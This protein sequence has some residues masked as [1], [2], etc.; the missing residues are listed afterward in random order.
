MARS[1]S[2][3][4]TGDVS[5]LLAAFAAAGSAGK[6]FGRTMDAR[7][8]GAGRSMT[9][10]LTLPVVA[11]F[12]YAAKAAG[13]FETELNTFQA[14]SGATARQLEQ[15]SSASKK[16]GADAKL[17]GASA[18][19]A[20]VAMTELAKGGLSVK[21]SMAAARGTLLLAAAAETDNAT[22][23]T[24]VAD[25]LNAFGLAGKDAARV[26]DLLAASANASTASIDDMAQGLKQSS[27]VAKQAGVPVD[28]ATAALARLA[29]AGIKGSD[30]G[31]SFKT[32]L[33]RLMAPAGAGA[34][35]IKELGLELRDQQGRL[36]PLPALADEF[37]SKLKEMTPAQRDA[38]LAAIF[39]SDAIRAANVLLTKGGAAQDQMRKKVSE[40][41]AAQK[42][43]EA[44]MKGFN[45]ALEAFSSTAETL[46]ITLGA[47]LL[48][49][50]TWVLR[51]FTNLAAGIDGLPGPLRGV[52][53]G[54]LTVVAAAG[55]MLMVIGKMVSLFGEIKSAVESVKSAMVTLNTTWLALNP[56]LMFLA[57]AGGLAVAMAML[58]SKSTTAASAMGELKKAADSA[59]DAVL[60]FRDAL[61]G[62]NDAQTTFR[63]ATLDHADALERY[64]DVQR[65]VRS[66]EITGAA[67]K[68]ELAA[69]ELAVQRS[70]NGVARARVGIVRANK[71]AA[72]SVKELTARHNEERDAALRA[73]QRARTA[74]QVTPSASTINAR[75]TAEKALTDTLNRQ[76]AELKPLIAE[77]AKAGR[78]NTTAGKQARE[79]NAALRAQRDDIARA[80]EQMGPTSKAANA[81]GTAGRNGA[82]GIRALNSAAKSTP[83][84]MATAAAGAHSAGAAIS[85]GLINGI[86]S[87]IGEIRAASARVAREAEAAQR[88]AAMINSPSKVFRRL[89]QWMGAG[90]AKGLEDSIP[91][92]RS[93][94]ASVAREAGTSTA[95]GLKS[96]GGKV[97]AAAKELAERAKKALTARITAQK[98][99]IRT[100]YERVA[101]AAMKA[102][103]D[104]TDE[105]AA[106]RQRG[107]DGRA[108]GIDQAQ[109]ALTPAEAEIQRLEGARDAARLVQGLADAERDLAAAQA[110]GDANAVAQA[111]RAVDDARLEQQ[112]A[113][114][115]ER[116]AA[117][118]AAQ[119]ATAEERRTALQEEIDTSNRHFEAMRQIQRDSLEAALEAEKNKLLRGKTQQEQAQAQILAMLDRAGVDYQ[120][121]GERLGDMFA[122]GLRNSVDTVA[123][124]AA[125]LADTSLNLLKLKGL[126]RKGPVKAGSLASTDFA[127]G[128]DLR[129]FAGATNAL[130]LRS[131]LPAPQAPAGRA[132]A[133]T[134]NVT[135]VDRTAAGMSREQ[136][137]RLADDIAPEL[138]RR[139]TIAV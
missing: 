83:G 90:T 91:S 121:A 42:V 33:M 99:A 22:A 106:G 97:D 67:A 39:G 49:A 111:Q 89:G 86:L 122:Q 80:R 139:V 63:Q 19:D 120:T 108:A 124:A 74:A 93:A 57:V 78:A 40:Q 109:A 17:P 68:R 9:R 29:N 132:G 88:A 20:A 59:R 41:G 138:A 82:G 56:M 27:A 79:M 13:D 118:R 133:P 3:Q 7:M 135:V 48:P 131:P 125:G 21:E 34:K 26:T 72:T 114:L 15:V 136:A 76:A 38:A 5:R 95:S 137:R 113:G 69:A 102:F 54:L 43:A 45:G 71:D 10:G 65:R 18:A 50:L 12:G 36:K 115:K 58:T 62:Q 1:I 44:K 134:V 87:K 31:T 85:Q 35:K 28:Q 32:M 64:A 2:V 107:F 70:E 96:S 112:L 126:T 117:E 30:A 101:S 92:V 11:G 6:A 4:F 103:D 129:S 52:A 119:D 16:L 123:G 110:E 100:A 66:G 23:A 75:A 84:V 98:Q 60:G 61:L 128:F 81:V 104:R 55:P 105:L 127:D 77:T 94:A 8:L 14:V 47:M 24:I 46:S 73:V 130:N 37:T 116:A 51:G 25:T 53:I